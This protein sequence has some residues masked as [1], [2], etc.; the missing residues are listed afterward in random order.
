MSKI[1]SGS[2]TVGKKSLRKG[3]KSKLKNSKRQM[4][5]KDLDKTSLTTPGHGRVMRSGRAA[6]QATPVSQKLK[7]GWSGTPMITPK[8]NTSSISRTVSRVARANEV[9]VSLDGSPVIPQVMC[10][11]L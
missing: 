4:V 9:L 8:F 2:S 3:E 6:G 10:G 1:V 11:W 5:N 7:K